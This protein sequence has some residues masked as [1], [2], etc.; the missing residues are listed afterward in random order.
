MNTNFID[1]IARVERR[2]T[3]KYIYSKWV[4]DY[5]YSVI[6]SL[7]IIMGIIDSNLKNFT[8]NYSNFESRVLTMNEQEYLKL[9]IT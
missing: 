3:L 6:D 2:N 8:S 9:K 5:D 7:G 4:D 1:Y